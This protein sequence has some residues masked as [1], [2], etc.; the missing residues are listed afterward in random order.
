MKEFSLAT[1][2]VKEVDRIVLVGPGPGDRKRP[3]Y[4]HQRTDL[5]D[6]LA[7]ARLHLVALERMQHVVSGRRPARIEGCGGLER[8]HSSRSRQVRPDALT[9]DQGGAH[10]IAELTEKSWS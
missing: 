3:W 1:E 2:F 5:I 8:P 4:S 6:G 7:R 10:S 9:I